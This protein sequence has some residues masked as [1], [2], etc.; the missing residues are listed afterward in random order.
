MH[1]GGL[2]PKAIDDLILVFLHALAGQSSES[3]GQFQATYQ[4][5]RQ[6]DV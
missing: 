4:F 2:P 6:F 1:F 3:N 5:L